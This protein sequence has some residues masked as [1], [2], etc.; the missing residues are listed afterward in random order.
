MKYVEI[1]ILLHLILPKMFLI[2]NHLYP[3][4]QSLVVVIYGLQEPN[5]DSEAIKDQR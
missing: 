2:Y 4:Y 1:N 3:A 5:K